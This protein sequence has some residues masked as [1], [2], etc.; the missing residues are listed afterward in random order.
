MRGPGLEPKPRNVTAK[1]NGDAIS[2]VE[3]SETIPC[4]CDS[5]R[6]PGAVPVTSAGVGVP[7]GARLGSIL[8]L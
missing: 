7:A 4:R 2:A 3:P 6:A 1:P 5:V 8:K